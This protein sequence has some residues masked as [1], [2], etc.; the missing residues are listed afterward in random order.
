MSTA[1]TH[2]RDEEIALRA[3]KLARETDALCGNATMKRLA[4]F[5]ELQYAAM[6]KLETAKSEGRHL[7]PEEALTYESLSVEVERL[8]AEPKNALPSSSEQPGGDYFGGGPGG[9]AQYVDQHGVGVRMLKPS[10]RLTDAM[11]SRG[12]EI[13]DTPVAPLSLGKAIIGLATSKWDGAERERL[14]MAAGGNAVGGYLVGDEFSSTVIDYA[15]NH[16]AVIKAG[17]ITIPWDGSDTLLM[18]RVSADPTFAVV[19]ENET[20]SEQAMTFSNRRFTANKIA[21]IV[22]MSRELAEDSEN[23][24]EL[25]ET[26]IAKALGTEL[27]RLGLVGSGS[28]EPNGLLLYTG[29]QKTDSIGAIAWEDVHAAAIAVET[30]NFTPNAYITSPTVGGNLDIQVS[31]DGANAAKTWLG[32]PPSLDDVPRFSTN[33]CPDANLFIGDWSQFIFAIRQDA[34]IEVTTTGGD[35]FSKHQLLV[36]CTFRGDVGCLDETAFH[37]LTGITT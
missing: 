25:V 28:Q 23:A 21:C 4:R 24:A 9:G 16:A 22:A 20:I 14:A 36:K 15:R 3:S 12:R 29:I 10:E 37:V 7:T 8:A 26:T 35:S 2:T 32:H 5:N 31:G 18:A 19:G 17:G 11:L 34:M 33:N 13:G 1:L 27:D 6:K 30:N